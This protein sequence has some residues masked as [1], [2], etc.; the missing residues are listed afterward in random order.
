MKT[1]A[2]LFPLAAVA[3]G[4]AVFQPARAADDKWV[5]PAETA[6]LKAGP[7]VETATLSC[8]L[9]HSTD[10]ISTQPR[11]NRTQWTVAVLKMQAKYG[12]P[13]TTNNVAPLVDYLVANY[14][15][16]NPPV[17]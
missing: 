4:F 3:V 17:K 13:I 1:L 16:E 7:G 2:T 10:Y 14:G 9:C 15:K 12:A 5:L 6:K 8:I 11:L